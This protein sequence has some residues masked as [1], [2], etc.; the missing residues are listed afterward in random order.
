VCSLCAL[1]ISGCNSGV[2][3]AK[4]LDIPLGVRIGSVRLSP[5]QRKPSLHPAKG[6]ILFEV[7]VFDPSDQAIWANAC[8]GQAFDAQRDLLYT[9][10]FGFAVAGAY[11]GPYGHFSGQVGALVDA[12]KRQ[13]LETSSATATC[14]AWD[15][16][17]HPPI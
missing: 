14:Q 8:K 4:I 3:T 16:G 9:F 5:Q 1:V 2:R 11:V 17:G 15:W 13:I 7:T 6:Y 12:S 10:N